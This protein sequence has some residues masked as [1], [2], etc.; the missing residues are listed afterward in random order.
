V[1]L[2]IDD[3]AEVRP[4]AKE[5]GDRPGI[6]Q[7]ETPMMGRFWIVA[8]GIVFWLAGSPAARADSSAPATRPSASTTYPTPGELIARMHQTAQKQAA[9]PKVAYFD[10][11]DPI[12]EKP[13]AFSLFGTDPS[14]TLRSLL[15]RLHAARD[16]QSVQ[17]VL[18]TL[19]QPGLNLS[20]AHEVRDALV[21]LGKA[22]KRTFV[23]AD[24]YDTT[25]YVL[26]TGATD[27]CMLG[28]GEIMIPGIGIE[29]MFAKGLL[30]KIG[31]QADYVQIGEYKGADEQFTRTEPSPELRGELN[32]L[33]DSLYGQIVDGI[34]QYR[35]LKPEAVQGLIDTA[36]VTAPQAKEAGFV[37]HLV[38]IDGL[39]EL[40][41]AELKAGAQINL[42]HDYGKPERE[43][44]DLSSP[45]ALF[46]LLNRRPPV[47]TKPSVAI[48]Y[49]EGT[50][51][52]GE[53]GGGLFGGSGVGSQDLREAFRLASRDDLVKAIVLRIDSPGGSALA[54]EAMWQAARRAAK[55]KPLIVSVGSMAA[56]GG[57]YLASAGDRIFADPTAIVGSIGVVGGKFVTRDL[58]AKLGLNTEVFNR[59]HNADLF[60]S[61]KPFSQQQRKMVTAW[62]RQTYDQFTARILSTRGKK[63]KD[64]DKVARG[65][66]FTAE[67]AKSLGMVD[68]IGG[69][70]DAIHA[71]AAK[72]SLKEGMYDVKALPA[73]RTL[74]DLLSGDDQNTAMPFAPKVQLA[75]DSLLN[76][77]SPSV[78]AGLM[79]QLQMLQLL[80]DRPVILAAPFRVVV[81]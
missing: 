64:I 3:A 80:Q 67:Q 20:Q 29:T 56:S 63:I 54:S 48:I 53:G 28:G 14:N 58:F 9:L 23:Y 18:I 76:A 79:Q 81:R 68:D 22:G 7:M 69:L 36:L 49:A 77:L 42:V 59:G 10:L 13:E 46:A 5:R 37:D 39:R 6:L 30:D 16:D 12:H 1:A 26:A 47:S 62:M 44:L 32:H 34:A 55:N 52:D 74:A 38:D 51:V 60:S 8:L 31:V 41:A 45:F 15:E 73:P 35:K 57:Y 72:A 65:R 4:G 78:R 11:S 75:P 19:G 33:L 43:S 70:E 27:I 66:I 61:T 40:I 17:A 24:A 2:R 21:E 50:I 25:G 71:A